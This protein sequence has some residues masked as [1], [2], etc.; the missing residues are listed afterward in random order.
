[1]LGPVA[2][3]SARLPAGVAAALELVLRLQMQSR[4]RIVTQAC[5]DRIERC[6]DGTD[7]TAIATTAETILMA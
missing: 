7:Y 1:M 6:A 3:P 5:Q 2:S 4:K